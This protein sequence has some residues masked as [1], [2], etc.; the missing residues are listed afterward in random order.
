MPATMPPRTLR[1]LAWLL[2]GAAAS[3]AQTT[4]PTPAVEAL[5][6]AA[7]VSHRADLAFLFE[8]MPDADRRALPAGFLR[9]QVALANAARAHAP[10]GQAL[11][12]AL[13]RNF[14][15]PYAQ[16]D[17]RREDW[18]S[19]LTARCRELVAGCK[20]PGEAA[21]ALNRTLF[22]TLGV[23]YST[24][25]QRALQA[26][27]ESIAQGKASC[28]GLAI[29]LADACRAVA[30][31]ARLVSVRWPH[32]TG[33]PTWVE[34]WDGAAWRFVGADEPDPHGF[35]RAWFT[36]D[37]A[38]CVDAPREHRIWALSFAATGERFRPGW[39]G[40]E[41]HGIDVSARYAAPAATASAPQATADAALSAQ[42]ARFFAADAAAQA[43]FDFDR[44]LDAEVRTAAGDARL[45]KLAAAAFR[46]AP[47]PEVRADFAAARVRA[48][49]KESAYT[50]KTVGDRP[51]A[52][53]ALV[54]A[55][56]GGGGVP[57]AV[58]DQQWRQMQS[59]YRDH[60]EAGGYHYVALRAP[61]DEWN[62]FYTGYVYPL[63]EALIRQFVICGDVDSDKVCLI[64]YSHGGYGAFAIAPKL[65]H[66][67]AAAHASAAAPTDG[68]TSAVGLHSLAFSFMV[69]EF[70][71]A[72]GRRER[73]EAFA[74][75]LATLHAQAQD[76]Y[77]ARFL[78]APG[79]RHSG[80]PDRDLLPELLAHTRTCQPRELRW[81]LTCDQVRSHYWLHT[82]KPVPGARVQATLQPRELTVRGAGALEAVAGLD[83]RVCDLAQ[84]FTLVVDGQ[85][86]VLSPAPSLRLLCAQ[87]QASGDPALA[88]SW[89]VPLRP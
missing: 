18:R 28:T 21:L 55:L 78:F 42:L 52:G 44:N 60:P 61:T 84:P 70:D 37:A 66:R 10:W 62:G 36:G 23:H 4:Q 20:T 74:A 25:R 22:T 45:R 57:K 49:G 77:P 19:A 54:I 16:A 7:P 72:Y 24:Q 33:N 79:H 76:L 40:A 3:P 8:H 14:V 75:V 82:A 27:S 64:G 26:P 46:Q 65:P 1:V 88:G 31:P 59:Y 35:D 6:A 41:S 71:R 5:L 15:L 12:D 32:K 69:G 48:G 53:Y 87:M 89:L 67:F 47:H 83:A 63:I 51:A 38:R 39:G 73:C 9:E 2:A 68:E 80:L 56:H 85:R 50:R 81:E 13:F 17:E 34:V 58:N 11:D 29:L 86:Q 43:R 30:V